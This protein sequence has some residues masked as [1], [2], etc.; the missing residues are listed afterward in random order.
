MA[1]IRVV[2]VVLAAGDGNRGV[3]TAAYNL[4]NDE[5]VIR[6][7]GSKRVMLKN[8]QEAKFQK[9]LLPISRV[10]LSAADQTKVSFDAFFTHILMHELMHGLGPHQITVRGAATT[11]RRELK[12]TYSAIEE[13]KADVSGLWALQFLV[14]RGRVDASMERTMYTTFL[15]SAFRSIRFG[16]NEAHG[17]GVALQ[18]NTMLDRGAFVVAPDGTFS[19]DAVK[20]K[21][22]VEAL[23]AEIMHLE[24]AGDYAKAKDWLDR[25]AVLRPEVKRVLDRLT[26]V[27]VDIEPRFVTAD[28][29]S[30]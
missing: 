4:P 16:L 13:A 27:P 24:A 26:G 6:E 18:L 8:M 25:M 28:Q 17:R 12:E 5:R 3:Q 9:A 30:K 10:A 29:L 22:A 1:P 14:N 11:V 15:A 7:K 23:T 20:I 2:N 21:P 19:V